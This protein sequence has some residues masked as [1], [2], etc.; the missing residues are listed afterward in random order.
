M[1]STYDR[2]KAFAQTASLWTGKLAG[3]QQFQLSQLNFKHLQES[4]ESLELPRIPMGTVLGKRAEYFFKFCIEQSANYELLAANT[5]IFKNK[6]TIGE[7][8][9]IIREEAT[10][11]VLHVELVY[12]F[13]IV[14]DGHQ[15]TS[16][17]LSADQNL[18]LSR[19]IGPNRRDS[20]IKKFDHLQ[21][22]QLP[23]LYKPETATFLEEQQID[24]GAVQQQVCFLAH[25]FIP[26]Q[27]WQDDSKYINKRCIV[28]YYMDELAFA[29]AETSNTYYLP[30]KHAWKMQPHEL[31][32]SYTHAQS[33]PIAID[34]LQR[35]FAPLIWM[36]L[37]D[38]TFERFFIVASR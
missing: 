27:N 19:Y 16:K 23:L 38:G 7:L 15:R 1:H 6:T 14:E 10:Q 37:A 2:F 24:V 34:S 36:Q 3:V 30:E 20:F 31:E 9:Y 18:H 28:G 33:L 13:Y 26:R 22:R 4:E 21:S 17:F 35:G 8:D 32:S 12:K 11:Q 5:Q 29:K 25:V